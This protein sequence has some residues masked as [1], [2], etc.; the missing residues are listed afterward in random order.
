M[1]MR[2]GKKGARGISLSGEDS[3]ESIPDRENRECGGNRESKESR[4]NRD[5]SKEN[6]DNSKESGRN[7]LAGI[8]IDSTRIN[9]SHL[10]SIS[11]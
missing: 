11:H 8:S 5:N 10:H 9:S 7:S 1:V 6:R 3:Q 4:E 2:S